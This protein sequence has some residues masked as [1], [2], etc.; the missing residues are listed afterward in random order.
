MP[1][2]LDTLGNTVTLSGAI[3][4]SGT[5]S[6]IGGGTL[7][8]S[9][10]NPFSGTTSINQ[11]TL[12]LGSSAAMQNSTVSVNTDNGLTFSSSIGTFILG[13]LSGS[14]AL[15]L[16]NT[17]GAPVNIVVGGNNQNTT[18]S[19][20][21]SGTGTLVKAGSGSLDLTG[22]NTWYGG[23]GLEFDPGTVAFNSDAVLGASTNPIV[24]LGSGTLQAQGT[25]ALS[26]SRNITISSTATAT[27]DP[28]GNTLTVLGIISGQGALAVAGSGTLVLS[29]TNTYSGGTFVTSGALE[30]T[31]TAAL[32]G[33]FT[34][35]KVSVGSGASLVLAVGGPQEWTASGVNLLLSVSGLFQPGSSFSL[36]ASGGSFD[37][38][39]INPRGVALAIA[40]DTTLDVG[41]D[42]DSTYGGQIIGSGSLTKV[43]SGTRVLSGSND[44]SG[45]TYVGDGTLGITVPSALLD[46]ADLTIGDSLFFAAVVPGVNSSGQPLAAASSAVAVPEPGSLLLLLAAIG[47]WGGFCLARYW[48]WRDVD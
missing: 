30:A 32:P 16:S 17:G 37:I 8:L 12:Q 40:A 7:I 45:G 33:A 23:G 36:D 13:G 3:G 42:A 31:T 19:G 2:A 44:Y 11:G 21:L 34:A 1:A 9:G 28:G 48:C 25:I 18:F 41:S 6:A 4:G 15:S 26:P 5:M 20:T 22:S 46:G 24:F 39:S 35:G 10:S 14:G 29:N 43:G 38:G 27:L 47:V